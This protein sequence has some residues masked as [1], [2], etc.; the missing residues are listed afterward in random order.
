MSQVTV[1]PT[2]PLTEV[3]A[4][5]SQVKWT[6]NQ[7]SSLDVHEMPHMWPQAHT[8][9]N[10]YDLGTRSCV[11][12]FAFGE[13][14][15]SLVEAVVPSERSGFLMVTQ[16][17]AGSWAAQLLPQPPPGGSSKEWAPHSPPRKPRPL[18]SFPDGFQGHHAL[19]EK[20]VW[21]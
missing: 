20:G 8:W 7:V 2:G 3:G 12:W 11:Q 16:L 1:F 18:V 17:G 9:P 21:Q 15:D 5:G 10:T 4:Q 14:W 19:L 6:E 13:S